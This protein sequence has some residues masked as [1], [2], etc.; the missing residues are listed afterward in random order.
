M[1]L[2]QGQEHSLTKRLAI[3]IVWALGLALLFGASSY[4][5]W[6]G[7]QNIVERSTRSAT[8]G[9]MFG[10]LFGANNAGIIRDRKTAALVG[11][12]G[13]VIASL[14]FGATARLMGSELTADPVRLYLLSPLLFSIVGLV[15]GWLFGM[16]FYDK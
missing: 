11:L 10:L 6:Q 13:G 4:V 9:M 5:F 16:V 12:I 8:V 1:S 15:T 7:N 2:K 3:A 14:V